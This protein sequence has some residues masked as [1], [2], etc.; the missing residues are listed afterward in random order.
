MTIKTTKRFDRDFLKLPANIQSQAEK[1]LALLIQNPRH[2]SLGI[3][4]MKGHL[5]VWEGR[6]TIHY[7]FSFKIAGDVYWLNR[8]GT[9]EIYK[10]P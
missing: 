7:R 8:I 2:P 10:N 4:K 5:D 1:Q 9:H 6:V 3:K